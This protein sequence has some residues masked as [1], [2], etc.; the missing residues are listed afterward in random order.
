M[1]SHKACLSS[2]GARERVTRLVALTA[3]RAFR[4]LHRRIKGV[5][6]VQ[7]VKWMDRQSEVIQ[8]LRT[9]QLKRLQLSTAAHGLPLPRSADLCGLE[10]VGRLS[11]RFL[12]RRVFALKQRR[13]D[14]LVRRSQNSARMKAARRRP[15]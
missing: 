12:E 4:K 9:Q 13:R 14:A 10:L 11:S 8:R 1:L 15:L 2:K 3:A 7:V 6:D 5:V